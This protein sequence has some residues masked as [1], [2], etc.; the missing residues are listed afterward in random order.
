MSSNTIEK[1][2]SPKPIQAGDYG[3]ATAQTGD[4]QA[5]STNT[6]GRKVLS[7]WKC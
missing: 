5:E 6:D 3:K 7:L 1:V 2:L 4:K